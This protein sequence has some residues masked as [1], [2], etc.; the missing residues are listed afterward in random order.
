MSADEKM[1]TLSNNR[2]P[3]GKFRQR[4]NNEKKEF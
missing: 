1:M 2:E 3:T 4:K